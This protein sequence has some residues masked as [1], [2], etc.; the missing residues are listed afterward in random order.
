MRQALG[1]DNRVHIVVRRAS[2]PATNATVF[3][4]DVTTGSGLADAF[5]GADAV[6]HA[7]GLA[8][9]H[10]GASAAEL[11]SVNGEAAG[12]VMRIAKESGV[13]QVVILSSISV[14]GGTRPGETVDESA[15]TIPTTPYGESKLLGERAASAEAKDSGIG[16]RILRLATVFGAGDPGNFVRLIRAIHRRHFIQIGSGRTLKSLVHRSDA[17]RACLAAIDD[18]SPGTKCF[19]VVSGQFSL[20]EIVSTLSSLLDVPVLPLRIPSVIAKAATAG[21]RMLPRGGSGLATSIERLLSDESYSG[22]ALES[23]YGFCPCVGLY[24]GLADEVNWYL[25]NAS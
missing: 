25:A 5:R 9:Q 14:Y 7:A 24:Q 21:L 19:N 23:A 2:D 17:A 16:L 13:S 8:H 11:A 18:S 3:R 10:R 15:P 6:I 22:A 1:R 12:R 4:G 20:R